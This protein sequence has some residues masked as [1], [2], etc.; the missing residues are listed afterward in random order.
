MAQLQ[1]RT[2]NTSLLLTCGLSRAACAAP[3]PGVKERDEPGEGLCWEEEG[4]LASPVKSV[5]AGRI[6]KDIIR[7]IS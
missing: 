1:P 7:I 2:M 4:R 3:P 5:V 6:L